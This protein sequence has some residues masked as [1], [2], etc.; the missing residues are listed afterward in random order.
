MNKATIGKICFMLGFLVLAT[1][2]AHSYHE[3]KLKLSYRAS[4]Q[5]I[6]TVDDETLVQFM[7][8]D[9]PNYRVMASKVMKFEPETADEFFQKMDAMKKML[10]C[11]EVAVD[12]LKDMHPDLQTNDTKSV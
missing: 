1:V 5:F 9:A 10:R 6:N 3:Y 7:V 12:I 8:N 4:V 2:V 11:L